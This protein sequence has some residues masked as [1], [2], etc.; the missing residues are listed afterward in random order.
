MNGSDDAAAH[1]VGR[2]G[3]N[4]SLRSAK[5][6]AA[7]HQGA[8]KHGTVRQPVESASF[9]RGSAH[10]SIPIARA[11]SALGGSRPSGGATELVGSLRGAV[12]RP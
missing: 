1:P 4:V 5:G 7:W 9:F 8:Q 3:S 10:R 6:L 2:S 12:G 11:L